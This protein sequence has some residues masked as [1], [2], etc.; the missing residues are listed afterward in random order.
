MSA[1]G[2][3]RTGT[4]ALMMVLLSACATPTMVYVSNAESQDISVFRL[5][6]AQGTLQ[7]VQTRAVGGT[8]MPMA[9]SADRQR[10]YAAIRSK[11]YSVVALRIDNRDGTLHELG[12]AP[13]ADSMA[14]IALDRGNKLILS[15]SYGGNKLS[16]NPLDKDGVPQAPSQIVPTGPMAHQV[17]SSPDGRFV[18]ASVLGADQLIRLDVDAAT[19]RL[20]GEPVV[21]LQLPAQSGPRHFVFSTRH[22]LIY[23]LDELDGRLHVLRHDAATGGAS[24]LQTVSVVPPGFSGK[25]AAADL[26]LTPDGRFL[27]ASERGSNT[28]AGFEVAAADGQLRLIDHWPTE[29]QPRGFNISP[30]GRFLLAVGQKSHSLTSYRIDAATGRLTEVARVPTGK[31][32]NWVEIVPLR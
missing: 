24:L 9:V 4:A 30:D 1:T 18:Y 14:N 21:A 8:V 13:L 27:Y 29:T 12:A 19:G 17:S 2:F 26:H 16:V 32:P 28:L 10:L 5:D 31:G 6:T 25:P 3:F 7:P 15:A 20:Q 23:L 11:P 22:A